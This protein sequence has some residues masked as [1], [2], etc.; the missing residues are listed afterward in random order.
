MVPNF[1]EESVHKKI[2]QTQVLSV[3]AFCVK[4]KNLV[5]KYE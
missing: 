2:V 5:E 4:K 3:S 1:V